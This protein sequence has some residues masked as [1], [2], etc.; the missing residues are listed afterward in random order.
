[1]LTITRPK[2]IYDDTGKKTEVIL[3]VEDF[4]ALLEAHG[5]A[6]NYLAVTE[7]QIEIAED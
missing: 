2:Y 7:N 3:S 4:E 5:K 6:K 1:M